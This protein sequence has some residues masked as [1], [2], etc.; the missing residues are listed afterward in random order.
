MKQV[1]EFLICFGNIAGYVQNFGHISK[2]IQKFVPQIFRYHI[3]LCTT[4]QNFSILA[5]F[6]KTISIS[7]WFWEN[8]VYKEQPKFDDFVKISQIFAFSPI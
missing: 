1:F 8:R 6:L 5:S 2:Q 3:E 7:A 4:R